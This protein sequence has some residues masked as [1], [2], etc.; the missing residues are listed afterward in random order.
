MSH[1][2]IL[3][4]TYGAKVG[5]ISIFPCSVPMPV[6]VV[7]AGN[8]RFILSACRLINPDEHD[9]ILQLAN[10]VSTHLNHG[11]E[12]SEARFLEPSGFLAVEVL[13]S[14]LAVLGTLPATNDAIIVDEVGHVCPLRKQTRKAS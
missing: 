1:S 5:E 8:I 12:S 2:I 11:T 14:I 9:V 4:T 10:G 7:G 6:E 13:H 3:V